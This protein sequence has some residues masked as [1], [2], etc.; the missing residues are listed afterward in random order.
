MDWELWCGG[1]K[2]GSWNNSLLP[3][4]RDWIVW[5][6]RTWRID[7]RTWYLSGSGNKAVWILKVE[8]VR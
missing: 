4:V 1:T 5:D 2:V 3:I 7:K 8:C 6:T